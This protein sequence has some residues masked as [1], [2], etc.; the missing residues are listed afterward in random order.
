MVFF[1]NNIHYFKKSTSNTN[2]IKNDLDSEDL[3]KIENSL[4][5]NIIVKNLFEK[6]YK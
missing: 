1:L 6:A 2:P 5:N 4:N 3:E